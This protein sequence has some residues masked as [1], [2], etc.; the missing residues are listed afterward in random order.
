MSVS[1]FFGVTTREALRQVRMA[2][3]P[4]ALI[5][6][7]RRVNGG[8]EI[9]ATDQTEV[10]A[11]PH[12]ESEKAAVLAVE[13]SA[14]KA[15]IPDKETLDLQQV[16]GDLRGML[17]A[18][19]DEM[20]WGQQ[21]QRA[22]VV[23]SVFQR[24]LSMGFSTR[25]LRAMLKQL[26]NQLSERAALDWCRNELIKHLP[27]SVQEERTLRAGAVV[28]LVGPTGVGKTTTIAKL[29]AR[30]VRRLGAG[31][32]VLLTTDT[33]RI[34][35]HEQLRI[36]GRLLG[37]PVHVAE[38]AAQLEA[39]VREA[40]PQKLVLIDNIGVSQRD[41]YVGAQASLLAAASARVV[42]LLA[43]NAASHGDTLDE[44]ARRYLNDGGPPVVG[45]LV[46]KVDEAG[47]LAPVLDTCIRHRLPIHF[48]STGQK[49]PED[50]MV[51]DASCL[52]DRALSAAEGSALFAPSQADLAMLMAA[53]GATGPAQPVSSS[54]PVNMENLLSLLSG[55]GCDLRVDELEA[56]CRRVDEHLVTALA[57]ERFHQSG[58]TQAAAESPQQLARMERALSVLGAEQAITLSGQVRLNG[59]FGGQTIRAALLASPDGL[60]IASPWQVWLR[61]DGWVA[62]D[63]RQ[64]VQIPAAA[65]LDQLMEQ[66]LAE[67][68]LAQLRV[69][70][71]KPTVASQQSDWL[72]PCTLRS[73]LRHEGEASV[74]TAIARQLLHQPVALQMSQLLCMGLGWQAQEV[75]WWAAQTVVSRAMRGAEEQELAF[76]SLRAQRRS[77]GLVLKQWLAVAKLSHKAPAPEQWG[78]WLLLHAS[79][80]TIFKLAGLYWQALT[81]KRLPGV[82]QA[83]VAVQ[84]ALSTAQMLDDPVLAKVLL[85]LAEGGSP[86]LE[87]LSRA[88]CKLFELKRVL[89]GV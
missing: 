10:L 40:G 69:Y 36:Y 46:T 74:A 45:C 34:G 43:L 2:L 16:V 57:Y 84:L 1:R 4:E 62:S 79:R 37:V 20:L 6:S 70:E 72:A 89:S 73:S 78:R 51:A 27:V 13:P 54:R 66:F 33:Y 56:A 88:G 24:L 83:G 38:G 67:G 35:A 86:N 50:M 29:A 75:Q 21:L 55:R 9:L 18:R 14:Q 52:V 76:F 71:G 31:N 7:N 39:L 3:G 30:C 25:L 48:V 82:Q 11:Q 5:V 63:G 64:G 58:E 41:Q 65:H 26:P 22:P 19:M 80:A 59:S 85:A 81:H 68:Q 47:R 42:R 23:L 53:H 77:D 28:A 49:V 8:V 61:T 32:V 15:E 60:W 44:V 87:N 12:T 17:E